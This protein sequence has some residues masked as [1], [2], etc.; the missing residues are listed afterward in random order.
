MEHDRVVEP[1]DIPV[2][3]EQA[4]I[5]VV[6]G[7]RCEQ[8]AFDFAFCSEMA[9]SAV[10]RFGVLQVDVESNQAKILLTKSLSSVRR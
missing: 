4:E 7:F 9:A 2:G 10:C 5:P 6:V 3:E 1:E 8:T